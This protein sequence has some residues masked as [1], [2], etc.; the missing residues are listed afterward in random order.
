MRAVL[1][2]VLLLSLAGCFSS[3]VVHFYVLASPEGEDISARDR[4]AEGPRVA[5]MPV[6]LPGYLQRPQMVVRQG[7]D[8]D[9]RI[10]DFHRWGEDLSLGIA[11][12]LS[13]TMT[14]DMR[15][16]RGVAMPLRT[17]APADYRAQV[18]IRRFEGAPGGKVQLEAAWSLSRDG[19][20]LRDGVFRTE[21]E[22]GA[23]MADMIEAQSDLLEE[24][25]SEL[26]RI[27][28]AADAGSSQAQRGRDGRQSQG[29]WKNRE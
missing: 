12:V 16:R 26:A 2:L 7:D 20:T 8:V 6:S 5:I 28:L 24:L 21:G 13:L 29:G 11:R 10:E 14:R 3:P 23:S 15:S 22:A 18:D 4:E 27:T 9:I 17:G 1:A 19:K 25:G